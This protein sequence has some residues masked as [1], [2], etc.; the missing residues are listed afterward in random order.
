LAQE[1]QPYSVINYK[2]FSR[3]FGVILSDKQKDLLKC[4]FKVFH[5][6]MN[7]M[8]IKMPMSNKTFC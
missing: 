7:K 2:H 6:F 5:P 8:S 1:L 4:K 3:N